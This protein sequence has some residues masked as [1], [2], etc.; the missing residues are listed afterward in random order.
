VKEENDVQHPDGTHTN[1]GP[2]GEITHGDSNFLVG[3]DAGDWW[4]ALDEAR[5]LNRGQ[6]TDLHN[7]TPY[8]NVDGVV[9]FSEDQLGQIYGGSVDIGLD[10]SIEL[11]ECGE[12]CR[13]VAVGAGIGGGA[14]IIACIWFCI[15]TPWPVL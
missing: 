6:Y 4:A 10:L 8:A 11:P 12:T 13:N 5:L 7:I 15:P 9:F 1:V 3:I 2:D 14:V